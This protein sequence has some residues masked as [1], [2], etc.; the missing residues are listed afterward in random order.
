MT[1]LSKE[2]PT[3]YLYLTDENH[4][5][6][7]IEGGGPVPIKLASAYL[8]D[9]REGTGTPDE[10][11]IHDSPVDLDSFVQW[12]IQIGDV[13]NMTISNNYYNGR[14]MPNVLNASKYRED[15][16]VLCFSNTNDK[17]ICHGLSKKFCVA[18]DDIASL[19]KAL[20]EQI[21]IVSI[22]KSCK[23]T[24]THERNHFLKHEDD[25]WMDEYRLFWPTLFWPTLKEV[26][27]TIPAGTARYCELAPST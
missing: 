24:N 6:T 25:G 19:K 13:K 21:G 5:R 10:T 3:K 23:Y 1:T 2:T 17:E 12:G 8:S 20:D 14:P 16:L 15:G 4:A 18:I 22:A 26:F 9:H 11:I 27:V 7:W